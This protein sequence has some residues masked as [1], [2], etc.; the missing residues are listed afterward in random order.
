MI[1]QECIAIFGAI[2]ITSSSAYG[3]EINV[4]CSCKTKHNPSECS[5]SAQEYQVI[6][7]NSVAHSNPNITWDEK[8][9]SEYCQRHKHIGCMCEGDNIYSGKVSE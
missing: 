4:Q 7:W 9:L 3:G 6:E 2:A 8:F 1:R 5:L